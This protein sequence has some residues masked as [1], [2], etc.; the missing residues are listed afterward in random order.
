MTSAETT[1]HLAP[2]PDETEA[3]GLDVTGALPAELHG[4]YLRNGPNPLPGEPASHLFTG[5]GM[6]HGIRL[7]DGRAEWYRNR[8]VRT[9]KLTGEPPGGDGRDLTRHSANT[10]VIEHGGH[11]LALCEAGFPY[12][13][14]G[15]L[16]TLGP[17]NFHGRLTTAMTAHPK[18]DPVTGELLFYGY[19]TTEPYVT[20]HI[21]DAA[22]DLVHSEPLEV[23]G[24]TMM[25]DFAI[26]E[27]Y[28]L[29]LDLP[30]VF[31]AG[32]AGMPYGWDDNYGAR[33]G[34]LPRSGGPVRWIEI[35]PCYVFHVGNA[36]EDASGAIVLDAVRY[37]P[38]AFIGAWHA[39]GGDDRL[40]T[41]VHHA[42]T[43]ERGVLHR[44]TI[45][46]RAGT[47]REQRLDDRAV[48]FP[49]VRDEV[50][51][52]PNRYL[53]TMGGAGL[54]KY[55]TERGAAAEYVAGAGDHLGEAVFVPA[56]GASAED[57][58]WLLTIATPGDGSASRLLVLDATDLHDV[59]AVRLP[60]RV[61]RGF[62]GSWIEDAK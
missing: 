23:P 24:P 4:R 62:H 21:A 58:G 41:R 33:I 54:V 6:L 7:R 37:T 14:S 34:V 48:E 43:S 22:G 19:S 8:W 29:W 26:T 36:R 42:T 11:L 20:F 60:R 2:V 31:R 49:T 30:A 39:P 46:P 16:D 3:F 15:E 13:M 40:R 28:V 47:V 12:R 56:A 25:H 10:H 45:D 53:Y 35:D 57:D 27:H 5:H 18:T 9:A 55:D 38:A 61:P 32:S 17:Y 59:A 44:W 51:G 52:R 50:V 1:Y